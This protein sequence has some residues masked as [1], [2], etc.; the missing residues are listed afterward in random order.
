M[1][2]TRRPQTSTS[3]A[4]LRGSVSPPDVCRGSMLDRPTPSS[5]VGIFT[6]T[7]LVLLND[8]CW[9][10]EN[11]ARRWLIQ[12]LDR[13]DVSESDAVS[14]ASTSSPLLLMESYV[15]GL[16]GSRKT[17]FAPQ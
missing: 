16:A 13:L 3:G 10:R 9:S 12:R 2:A 15:T 14:V 5:I 1:S 11:C 4:G 17:L 6:S 8:C 7:S